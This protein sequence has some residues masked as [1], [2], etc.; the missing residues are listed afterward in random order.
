MGASPQ[1]VFTTAPSSSTLQ[2]EAPT[3]ARPEATASTTAAWLP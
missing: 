2:Y 3:S 1:P